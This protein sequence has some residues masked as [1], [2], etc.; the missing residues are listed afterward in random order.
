M[1]D[2]VLDLA[3][4][5][6]SVYGDEDQARQRYGEMRLEHRRD[7]RAQ[8]RHSITLLQVGL[9]EA[10]GQAVD[11]LFELFVGVAPVTVDHGGLV[12]EHV[13]ATLEEAHRREL[14]TVNLLAHAEVPFFL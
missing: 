7:V 1:V 11:P 14:R 6:A 5:Q 12:R 4:A 10:R 9:F 13:G 8:E 3:R 2:Y